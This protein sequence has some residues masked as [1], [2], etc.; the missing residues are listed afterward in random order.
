[1]TTGAERVGG[2]VARCLWPAMR[3]ARA[4]ALVAAGCGVTSTSSACGPDPAVRQRLGSCRHVACLLHSTAGVARSCPLF[5]RVQTQCA[6]APVLRPPCIPARPFFKP[7][8][9]AHP[10]R[11]PHPCPPRQLPLR[12]A[13]LPRAS[14]EAPK[15]AV[16]VELAA[17][18]LGLPAVDAVGQLALPQHCRARAVDGRQGGC[19]GAATARGEEAQLLSGSAA[20]LQARRCQARAGQQQLAGTGRQRT[21]RAGPCPP[22]PHPPCRRSARP[23]TCPE[24]CDLPAVVVELMALGVAAA[25]AIV[26]RGTGLGT[27]LSGGSGA[28]CSTHECQC[29]P[30]AEARE[31]GAASPLLVGLVALLGELRDGVATCTLVKLQL[32]E[33]LQSFRGPPGGK[34]QLPCW[35][36]MRRNPDAEAA[37]A[38]W[39]CCQRKPLPHPAA[40]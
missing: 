23:R 37:P 13:P 34:H 29:P 18:L 10:S 28:R 4:S 35:G 2:S 36:C 12:S 6:G 5:T 19:G 25:G 16:H 27:G 8:T 14:L 22:D 7:P 38:A 31:R 15:A 9:P 24:L 32:H 17:K 30:L 33:L 26:R 1:M 11:D 20:W 40:A 3:R 39:S 21:A